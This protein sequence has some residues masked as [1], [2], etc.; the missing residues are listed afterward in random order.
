MQRLHA[1]YPPTRGHHCSINA[2]HAMTTRLSPP[3]GGITPFLPMSYITSP[4]YPPTRGHHKARPSQISVYHRLSPH[5]G[6]SPR[7]YEM[8]G[9]RGPSIPP[10]VTLAQ[11]SCPTNALCSRYIRTT[12]TSVQIKGSRGYRDHCLPAGSGQSAGA[13]RL[14]LA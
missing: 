8:S 13:L 4:V 7:H 10:R 9:E 14:G 2:P 11:N 3:R 6:A 5:A 12:P 1:V